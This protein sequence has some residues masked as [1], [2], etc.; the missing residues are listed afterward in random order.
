MF[1]PFGRVRP[2]IGL[3]FGLGG[4]AY[5]YETVDVGTGE[6]VDAV[7][8][9]IFPIVGLHGGAHIFVAASV[10]VDLGL[11][12]EYAAPH[13]QSCDPDCNDFDKAG[14]WFNLAMPY[15]GLSAWF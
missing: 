8:R 10:S 2:W 3:R 13:A 9:S 1:G 12:F 11:T 7:D 15:A 6:V 4:A 5:H 14:D